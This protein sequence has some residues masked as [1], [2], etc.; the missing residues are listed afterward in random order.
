MVDSVQG[1]FR[2]AAVHRPLGAP[3]SC[4]VKDGFW[5]CAEVS[6]V[7]ILRGAS[8]KLLAAC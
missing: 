1:A 3:V 4:E 2:C 6:P 5:C 8:A 7:F